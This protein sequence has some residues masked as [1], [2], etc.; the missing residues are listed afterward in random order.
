MTK[1]TETFTLYGKEYSLST[2]ELARQATGSV[3]VSQGDTIMLVTSVVSDERKDYDF[4]PLTVDF[5]EKMYSVGRI[6]GGYLKRETRPSDKATLS[7]R[8]IDRP[9]RTGFADGFRNEVHIVATTL[10]VD[11]VNPPDV[12]SIMGASAALMVGGVPFD[13]PA[14]GVRIGRNIETGEFIVNPTFEEEEGSDLELTIAG[15]ADYI[16]MVEAGGKEVSEEDMLAA[17]EFGQKVI[18]EFCEAQLRFV[19]Q[20]TPEMKEYMV[21]ESVP[22]LEER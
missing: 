6:P 7:A 15:T 8:M 18:G 16:S 22:G 11:Q 21:D 20:L 13:G 1:I 2:G 9:I 10:Q 4:F 14:A 3:V 17:M 19:Q 12:V 5:I